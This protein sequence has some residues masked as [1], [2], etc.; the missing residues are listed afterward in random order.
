MYV[1]L[2][3]STTDH[4]STRWVLWYSKHVKLHIVAHTQQSGFLTADSRNH[5]HGSFYLGNPQIALCPNIHT[6][7]QY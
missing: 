3:N 4:M 1:Y 2:F 6:H 5:R 7:V